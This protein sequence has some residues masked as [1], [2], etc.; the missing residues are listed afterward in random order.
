MGEVP[1]EGMVT[2]LT[3]YDAGSSQIPTLRDR[4]AHD[5]GEGAC[6]ETDERDD[7][8]SRSGRAS[9][10]CAFWRVS[11]LAARSLMPDPALP[12]RRGKAGLRP[13]AT[14]PIRPASEPAKRM[15][16][17]ARSARVGPRLADAAGEAVAAAVVVNLSTSQPRVAGCTPNAGQRRPAPPCRIPPLAI[18]CCRSPVA[19]VIDRKRCRRSIPE[20]PRFDG[21]C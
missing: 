3:V 6:R 16:H 21:R 19:S 4:A 18:G 13:E 7:A 15:R 5:A 17:E 9:R 12:A 2:A 11:S 14:V 20:T 1:L 8:A 10:A